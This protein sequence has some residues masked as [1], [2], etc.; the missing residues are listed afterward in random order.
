MTSIQAFCIF[1]AM[2]KIQQQIESIKS[3]LKQSPDDASLLNELGVGYHLLGDYEQAINAYKQALSSNPD[4]IHT[5]H[6][7]LANSYYELQQIEFAVNHY[8]DALEIKPD[9]VPAMNNLADIY[10]LAEEQDKA[11]EMFQYITKVNPGDPIGHFNLGNHYLRSNQTVEAG[12]CYKKTIEIDPDF[13]EA[14]YNI[15]LILKHLGQH[16]EAIKYYNQCLEIEPQYGPARQDLE[17]CRE[18][19]REK[20]A[21]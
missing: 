16:E 21:S 4:Q 6:F 10:E 2:K 19:L 15:G 3:E 7:N 5:I 20:S 8:M 18:A 1:K 13:H 9:Y 11:R 14:Y 17:K 12:R